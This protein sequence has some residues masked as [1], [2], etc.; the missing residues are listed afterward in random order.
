MEAR[1]AVLITRYVEWLPLKMPGETETDTLAAFGR[2]VEE[3]LA[4]GP[5]WDIEVDYD[6]KTGWTLLLLD[7]GPS[8]WGE[9]LPDAVLMLRE[10]VADESK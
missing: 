2:F 3:C 4:N 7:D 8:V 6:F 9:T 1:G 10:I 5:Y